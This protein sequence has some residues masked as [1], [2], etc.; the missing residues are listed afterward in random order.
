MRHKKVAYFYAQLKCLLNNFKTEYIHTA[1]TKDE[2]KE[3][4][5]NAG[6]TTMSLSKTTYPERVLLGRW[7]ITELHLSFI[8]KTVMIS[9]F[10]AD[11]LCESAV[12]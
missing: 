12:L 7:K 3:T 1:I 9:Q 11:K 6:K 10:C 4:H 5:L 2:R 8:P